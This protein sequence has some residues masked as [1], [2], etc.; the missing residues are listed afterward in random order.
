MIEGSSFE[1]L[2]SILKGD[3]QSAFPSGL[4]SVAQCKT[5]CRR[6]RTP[7]RA[8][9]RKTIV[10]VVSVAPSGRETRKGRVLD[11]GSLDLRRRE[12]RSK[13]SQLEI[14]WPLRQVGNRL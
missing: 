4:L 10:T 13:S 6:R 12:N 2:S 8:V 1:L 5:G 11:A 14:R 9:K 3:R 7:C